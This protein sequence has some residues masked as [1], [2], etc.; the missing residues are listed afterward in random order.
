LELAPK[1]RHIRPVGLQVNVEDSV[2]EKRLLQLVV[3]LAALVPVLG[4]AASV[5]GNPLRG[6][7]FIG[8]QFSYA[9]G[10]LI[11]V[12]LCYWMLVP[13]IERNGERLFLLTMIVVVGGFCRAIGVLTGGVGGP[14]VYACLAMELV[15]AP[16]V[17]LWQTHL[18]RRAPVDA[19]A[20]QG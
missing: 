4:G 3:I 1:R 12:G 6:A 17:Y 8:S 13:R 20:V 11:G 7:G 5:V 9:N 10:L 15:V 16:S 2:M 18:A 14:G 19:M